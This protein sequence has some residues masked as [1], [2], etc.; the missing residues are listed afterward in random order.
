MAWTG[1]VTSQDALELW[2]D[3]FHPNMSPWELYI[4]LT[5]LVVGF[6]PTVSP[7]LAQQLADLLAQ[8]CFPGETK[9]ATQEGEKRIDEIEVG[10]YVWARS[11][12]TGEIGLRRV[13]QIF[14]NVAAALALIHS[15][16]ETLRATPEHPMWIVGEGWTS[17]KYL[18]VGDTLLTKDGELIEVT[19]LSHQKGQFTVYNFE[20][21]EFHS[22]FVGES[23]VWAHNT[24]GDKCEE[25]LKGV[26]KSTESPVRTT[27]IGRMQDLARFADDV[28]VTGALAD[29]D[30]L[31]PQWDFIWYAGESGDVGRIKE[32]FD[33]AGE[34]ITILLAGAADPHY[35]HSLPITVM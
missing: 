2:A 14:V 29:P 33:E 35:S 12:T 27:V 30:R 13:K 20:V 25:L 6:L 9:I 8:F 3:S 26:A 18:E 5:A 23:R 10:D 7:K 32:F 16:T 17:A 1:F 31:L 21:E 28:D 11:D 22:Y 4:R 34:G 15:G 19:G 24:G